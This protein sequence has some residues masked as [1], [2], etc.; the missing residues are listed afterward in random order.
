[1]RTV[2]ILTF[3]WVLLGR[4]LPLLLELEHSE[5]A[6]RGMAVLA[7]SAGAG[8]VVSSRDH[9]SLQQIMAIMMEKREI[10]RSNCTLRTRPPM[11]LLLEVV[12]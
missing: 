12:R 8:L 5:S 10:D 3:A 9:G 4:L 7:R 1:M 11:S 6:P 2:W